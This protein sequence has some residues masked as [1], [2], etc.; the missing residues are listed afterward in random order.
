MS[1]HHRGSGGRPGLAAARGART[2]RRG[3]PRG[4]A[5]RRT[6]ARPRRAGPPRPAHTRPAWRRRGSAESSTL[7]MAASDSAFGMTSTTRAAARGELLA[8]A[9]RGRHDA[10]APPQR[11]Q[12]HD[13]VEAGRQVGV[14][15]RAHPPV[16]PPPPVDPDRR[17]D[18]RHR[19]AR[20]DRLDQA[21]PAGGVERGALP[22]VGVHGRDQQ[23]L[24]GPFVA[25]QPGPDHRLGARPRPAA[26][27]P[28]PPG[29]AAC[30][31]WPPC[32]A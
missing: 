15:R 21:R 24:G 26:G 7:P 16:H 25:G 4:H 18:A 6:R 10:H 14:R 20:A 23:P 13:P 32:P 17:P 2:P 28:G 27:R 1:A 22:R 19:A 31:P 9:Q 3:P 12:H 5:A 29:R 30:G 8:L 11:R